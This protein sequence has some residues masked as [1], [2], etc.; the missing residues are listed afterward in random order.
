MPLRSVIPN[1]LPLA[2]L[3]PQDGDQRFAKD[4]TKDQS[5]QKRA[6]RSERDVPKQVKK[7]A[8]I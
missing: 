8:A 5:G 3:A 4:E 1:G 7:V 2:L 6:A